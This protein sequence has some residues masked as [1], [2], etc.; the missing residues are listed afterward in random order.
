MRNL[1]EEL[2]PQTNLVEELD[3]V[4]LV[5]RLDPTPK[6]AEP[7]MVIS[8]SSSFFER[9]GHQ[10]LAEA[11]VRTTKPTGR[12]TLEMLGLV[13]T[14]LQ[15]LDKPYNALQV[16]LFHGAAAEQE[17][18]AKGGKLPL[19]RKPE[20]REGRGFFDG[21]LTQ[22]F[23]RG[24]NH[25]EEKQWVDVRNVGLLGQEAYEKVEG[26]MLRRWPVGASVMLSADA[27][28]T[29][30]ATEALIDMAAIGLAAKAAA[31][32]VPRVAPKI[33]VAIQRVTPGAD[34]IEHLKFVGPSKKLYAPPPGY[35]YHITSG[36]VVPDRVIR[37]GY[38]DY[39]DNIFRQ[40]F[41][42][43]QYFSLDDVLL[44]DIM[45][46]V[47]EEMPVA[48]RALGETAPA[49][50]AVKGAA[51]TT[52]AGM[53]LTTRKMLA[54]AQDDVLQLS[55][56][57]YSLE[58]EMAEVQRQIKT[59][60]PTMAELNALDSFEPSP[61]TRHIQQWI[62]QT[63]TESLLDRQIHLNLRQVEAAK[64]KLTLMQQGRFVDYPNVSRGIRTKYIDDFIGAATDRPKVHNQIKGFVREITFDQTD[65]LFDLSDKQFDT[66]FDMINMM[67]KSPEQFGNV[68]KELKAVFGEPHNWVT[69]SWQ[70]FRR[71]GADEIYQ[72]VRQAHLRRHR[73]MLRR[74]KEWGLHLEATGTS[75]DAMR[76]TF[77]Y[78]DNQM[79][80][81]R[82]LI[83]TVVEP[84]GTVKSL[85][86]ERQ[87][88]AEI[89]AADFIHEVA[90][91]LAEEAVRQGKIGVKGKPAVIEKYITHL[92]ENRIKEVGD[93]IYDVADVLDIYNRHAHTDINIR[94]FQHRLGDE[95][96][97]IENADRA[98][99]AMLSHE[100]YALEMEPAL[101]SSYRMAELTG[102]DE[103][104]EYTISWINHAVRGRPTKLERKLEP[105]WKFLAKNV[106]EK[107]TFGKIQAKDRA[108]RQIFTGLR[109][110]NMSAAM[111]YS[112]SPI[113]RN[114][115]QSFHNASV[116]GYSAHLQGTKALF[117]DGGRATLKSSDVLVG[118][119][120]LES[121]DVSQLS[122]L[123]RWGMKGFRMVDEWPNVA[124]AHTSG[125]FYHISRDTA[126][127]ATV[128]KYGEFAKVGDSAF[129]KA[130]ARA[131][132]AGELKKI[133]N[134]TNHISML[135][136]YSY[137]PFDYPRYM[138]GQ[139]GRLFGQ[140]STWPS[141]YY[142]SYLPE[143]TKMTLTGKAPWGKL[144]FMERQMLT[145]HL[146]NTGTL[147]AV[148]KSVGVDMSKMLPVTAGK[149]PPWL[150]L[151]GPAPSPAPALQVAEGLGII[152]MSRGNERGWKEGSSKINRGIPWLGL[153]KGLIPYPTTVPIE[154][155]KKIGRG[156]QPWWYLFYKPIEGEGE[157]T[158]KP[159][160]RFPLG[161]KMTFPK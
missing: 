1:V 53:P 84:E 112:P 26:Y 55:T 111:G 38:T 96:G 125:L 118:R 54:D 59:S 126:A 13:T 35:V 25:R 97:L 91:E 137:I 127:Q 12:A 66:L 77:L 121:F 148:G 23:V 81:Y 123:E 2:D 80:R 133:V 32:V 15:W 113:L 21:P 34:Y 47:P 50:V 144:S 159:S 18:L 4:N 68:P 61:S 10:A 135:N 141:N 114:A 155:M 146:M 62:G 130:T 33:A 138:W 27:A 153:H 128:K 142:T 122:K 108:T 132:D 20:E 151:G 100:T 19:F 14:P 109:R 131:L 70:V 93:D 40:M 161:G 29:E 28:V 44:S 41:P 49:A 24:W 105:G 57:K 71:L 152:G 60:K 95:D 51:R 147:Y 8:P 82:A 106:I 145:R 134:W 45:R 110:A 160:R 92:F 150:Y 119:F 43:R 52:V 3:P 36:A 76:R 98:F 103:I 65:D 17:R 63:N 89:A 79:D 124:N 30:L 94:E 86:P 90:E 117:T 7:E 39:L 9:L 72:N 69:P 102:S 16:G 48:L 22:A 85:I 120:P 158:A 31:K 101:Q 115:T 139:Y 6:L 11:K 83:P 129:W 87:L 156:E 154:K 46:D 56:R 104:L 116:Y 140:F 157:P 42:E 37:A 136:Q 149:Y 73:Y 88:T 143:I 75:D 74:V 99:R 64:G 67:Q 58:R 78:A 107:A 5:E